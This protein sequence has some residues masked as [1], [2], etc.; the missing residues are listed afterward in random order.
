MAKINT[1]DVVLGEVIQKFDRYGFDHNNYILDFDCDFIRNKEA[2]THS[3]LNI[4]ERL[5]GGAKAITIARES[6]C[7]YECSKGKL[8]SNE[9]QEWLIGLIK[10]SCC[11]VEIEKAVESI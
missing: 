11:G 5:I 6:T 7:V 8:T 4:L 1:T 9:I 3:N 10:K 2:M